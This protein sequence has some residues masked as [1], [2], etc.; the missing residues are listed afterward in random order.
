MKVFRWVFA[1]NLLKFRTLH[2]REPPLCLRWRAL[3][4]T[5]RGLG[6]RVLQE[7]AGPRPF[8]R[9]LGVEQ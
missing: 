8:A 1:A 4:A 5:A 2:E 6:F 9:L 7:S 3:L